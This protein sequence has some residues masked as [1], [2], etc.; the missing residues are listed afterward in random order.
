M[1]YRI[2]FQ[3]MD[4]LG[5]GKLSGQLVVTLEEKRKQFQNLKKQFQ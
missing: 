2:S 4:R 1:N 5:M 3:E